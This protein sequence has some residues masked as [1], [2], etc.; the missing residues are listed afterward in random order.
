[1]E[2]DPQPIYSDFH[3]L[4]NAEEFKLHPSEEDLQLDFMQPDMCN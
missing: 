4:G 1:M 3:T 2:V